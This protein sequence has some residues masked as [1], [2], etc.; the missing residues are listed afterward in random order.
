MGG[1]RH[2]LKPLWKESK[3]HAFISVLWHIPQ[4]IKIH[5]I[6]YSPRQAGIE[7]SLHGINTTRSSTC[8]R[9]FPVGKLLC[10][11][12]HNSFI[13]KQCFCI[14]AN[15]SRCLSGCDYRSPS[16][17]EGRRFPPCQ[18]AAVSTTGTKHGSIYT[19]LTGV[20][21][22]QR[23]HPFS[24]LVLQQNTDSWRRI[25]RISEETGIN[26]AFESFILL[27]R[28]DY[29]RRQLSFLLAICSVDGG[30]RVEVYRWRERLCV[31]W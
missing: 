10:K 25:E 7:P 29:V 15:I 28:E 4:T 11:L 12:Q 5:V 18:T 17:A 27:W 6:L 21:F 16:A 3:R 14:L 1:K 19:S 22:H 2:N 31:V 9:M 13:T 20:S 23:S 24:Q 30:C 8:Y 26:T